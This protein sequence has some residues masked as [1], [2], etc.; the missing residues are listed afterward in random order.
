MRTLVRWMFSRDHADV[1]AI[2]RE[3]FAEHWSDDDFLSA[4][5]QRNCNGMVVEHNHA[6][7]G[8]MVYELHSKH[9]QVLR[10]AVHS[11]FQYQ[12]FGRAMFAKL[13][14]KLEQQGRTGLRIVIRESN[15][16]GQLYF[17]SLGF[18]C[19][20]IRRNYFWSSGTDEA[21][22][23]FV[24]SRPSRSRKSEEM[25]GDLSAYEFVEHTDTRTGGG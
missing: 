16:D 10:F 14:D 1:F 7:V 2:D 21:G 3:C 12:G 22:Y 6:V 5:R 24:Y 25:E 15:I 8:F 17:K 13:L 9:L 11:N 19:M 4:L 18:K 20:D 23:E